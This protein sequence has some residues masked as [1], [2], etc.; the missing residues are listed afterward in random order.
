MSLR[1]GQVLVQQLEQEVNNL[2]ESLH[3][4]KAV[5]LPPDASDELRDMA[6]VSVIVIAAIRT[7]SLTKVMSHLVAQAHI[8]A[9]GHMEKKK[10]AKSD[11]SR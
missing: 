9:D 2:V 5:P 10:E 11:T 7:Q 4:M 1:A 3:K 6:D 8:I